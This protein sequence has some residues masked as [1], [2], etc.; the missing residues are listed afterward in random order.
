MKFMGKEAMIDL[1]ECL[2]LIAR[3]RELR[4]EI[5]SRRCY[6]P[7]CSFLHRTDLSDG[8]LEPGL[9]TSLSCTQRHLQFYSRMESL[10]R[11]S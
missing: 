5:V 6:E 4:E 2:P 10:T 9:F 1:V 7:S 8:A 11:S 3:F